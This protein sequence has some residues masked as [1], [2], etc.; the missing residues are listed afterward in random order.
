MVVF[1]HPGLADS[2]NGHGEEERLR[3]PD[4]KGQDEMKQSGSAQP[5]IFKREEAQETAIDPLAAVPDE[6]TPSNGEIPEVLKD[7][8]E[9]MKIKQQIKEGKKPESEKLSKARMAKARRQIRRA[10]K[11]ISEE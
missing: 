4:A 7:F 8:F 6:G 11:G 3:D 10:K 9:Q 5:Y 2:I 1:A